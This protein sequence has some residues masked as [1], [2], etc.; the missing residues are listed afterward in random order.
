MYWQVPYPDTML[1]V[2]L[3]VILP[4][5]QPQWFYRTT[6]FPSIYVGMECP[7]SQSNKVGRTPNFCTITKFCAISFS[8]MSCSTC[9]VGA[10]NVNN[11]VMF[12]SHVCIFQRCLFQLLISCWDKAIAH[13]QLGVETCR[14]GLMLVITCLSAIRFILPAFYGYAKLCSDL[15]W[16]MKD[17]SPSRALIKPNS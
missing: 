9:Y 5:M 17:L 6:K 2:V 14:V 16:R 11:I 12:V 13:C 8:T 7:K 10:Q 1:N 15:G 4:M 3:E